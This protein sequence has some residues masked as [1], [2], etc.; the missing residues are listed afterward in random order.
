MSKVKMV[1]VLAFL[2][3]VGLLLFP[4]FYFNELE[5]QAKPI[6][7]SIESSKQAALD[8]I[9]QRSGREGGI[10]PVEDYGLY[11]QRINE[12]LKKMVA[13]IEKHQNI[14]T[15]QDQLGLLLPPK[16]KTFLALKKDAFNK[17][18]VALKNFKQLKESE[19]D[20][21][22]AWM[23]QN[24]FATILTSIG[25]KKEVTTASLEQSIK[26]FE[27]SKE[28][29][30][31]DLVNKM[32]SEKLHQELTTNLDYFINTF[33]LLVQWNEK[34]IAEDEFGKQFKSLAQNK[35]D[36]DVIALINESRTTITE[37]KA[38]EWQ[39]LYDESVKLG[40]KALD[41]FIDNK[42]A[43]D[44][45]SQTLAKFN[46]DYPKAKFVKSETE[47][48]EKYADL[49]G[50]G[51]QEVIRLITNYADSEDP[52]VSLVAYDKDRKEIGRLPEA[53]PIKPPMTKT[54]KVFT[55]IAKDKNQ[56]VSFDFIAGPHSSE[57]M[58]F[59]L[60]E[61]KDDS[62]GIL[63]VCLTEEVK[64]AQD[65]LFWSGEVGELLVNDFDQDGVIEIAEVVDEYPSDGSVTKDIEKGVDETFAQQGEAAA[66]GA[67]RVLKR[68]QG[69]R[70]RKVVWG[71][72]H[73]NDYI[74]EK[75]TGKNYDKY[76]PL[77]KDYVVHFVPNYPA[78][79]KLSDLSPESLDYNNFMRE[80]WTGGI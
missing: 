15:K 46:K 26:E 75:Q 52:Q 78:L 39:T 31:K 77:V 65:C 11:T 61:L 1:I 72:Y 58:V 51:Q 43:E 7:I 54:A 5:S 4:S 41:F 59:G 69:G 28:E 57:T 14:L 60:F 8:N 12:N 49:N 64:G 47:I 29:I 23:Q 22:N 3:I 24:N 13:G 70:G 34:K 68:E 56:F 62:L 27:K 50:D 80:F 25:Q 38:D 71:I 19:T 18:Y 33:R 42:L 2:V 16:Y 63:P 21:Y 10:K 6:Y 9:E 67:L 32:I 55:P 79:I 36:I 37:V 35:K 74:F 66:E 45:L 17:Y 44:R 53:F 76:F 48:E 20:V 73:Y 40:N 30:K